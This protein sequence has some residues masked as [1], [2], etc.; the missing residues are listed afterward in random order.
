MTAP[1]EPIIT[2]E[3]RNWIGRKSPLTPLEIMTAPDV[4]R[5]VD[6]TGDANP[7]WLDDEFARAVDAAAGPGAPVARS[8]GDRRRLPSWMR[9]AATRPSGR[10]GSFRADSA[11]R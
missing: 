5:Y 1:A 8:G 4:R 7:L 10:S 9:Y 6:A 3:L 11:S 2:S